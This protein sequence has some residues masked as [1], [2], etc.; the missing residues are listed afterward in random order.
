MINSKG[1]VTT[2]AIKNKAGPGLPL[3]GQG[4]KVI[5]QGSAAATGL[6]MNGQ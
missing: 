1:K 2:L 4:L 6:Q 5:A 3:S